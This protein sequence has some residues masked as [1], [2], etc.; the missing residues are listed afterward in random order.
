MLQVIGGGHVTCAFHSYHMGKC[1]NVIREG[2]S[3][4]RNDMIHTFDPT[5]STHPELSLPLGLRQL[6]A[7]WYLYCQSA[8]SHSISAY[9]TT[10]VYPKSA[11][12]SLLSGAGAAFSLLTVLTLIHQNPS[13]CLCSPTTLP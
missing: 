7:N 3:T 9:D 6:H 10:L 12:L 2:Q 13:S 5:R 8:Y 11:V 4:G 1:E